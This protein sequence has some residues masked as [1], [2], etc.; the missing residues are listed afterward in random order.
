M[1]NKGI[2]AVVLG[3]TLLGHSP[4]SDAAPPQ[5]RGGCEA[6]ISRDV[7]GT[8]AVT[9]IVAGTVAV[10]AAGV[11]TEIALECALLV[12][13]SVRATATGSG[14]AVATAYGVTTYASTGPDEVVVCT[15][16]RDAART[17][18]F[19]GTPTEPDEGAICQ[20]L[21]MLGPAS[22]PPDVFVAEDGDVWVS[23]R[24]VLDCP[25]YRP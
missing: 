24:L 23:T 1:T 5:Y 11:P 14:A 22:Y 12:G 25:P 3:G 10:S 21:A 17:E 8:G 20:L 6:I 2:V 19:C 4:A 15:T 7:T 9:A 13:G 18:E 16:V